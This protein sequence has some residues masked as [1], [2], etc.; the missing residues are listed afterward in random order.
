GPHVVAGPAKVT[1]TRAA[2]PALPLAPPAASAPVAARP[3]PARRRGP[4]RAQRRRRDIIFGL[5]A[6]MVGSLAV[7]FLPGLRVLWGLHLL[8]DALFAVYVGLL[9]RNRNIA[10]ERE[11]KLRFLPG[12]T[13][14]GPAAVRSPE[15]ALLLRR[16]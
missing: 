16:T 1:M 7:G 5:F 8:L 9:I 13:G 15:P 10:A 12:P 11:M 3:V 2:S 6:A 4:T 14:T